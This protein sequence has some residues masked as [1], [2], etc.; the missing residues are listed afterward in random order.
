MSTISSQKGTLT[1]ASHPSH[2]ER[3]LCTKDNDIRKLSHSNS[4]NRS[5]EH[6]A[7]LTVFNNPNH[8]EPAE[9]GTMRLIIDS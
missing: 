2:L 9:T 5:A 6:V 3:E 7:L 1:L 8:L 4:Y